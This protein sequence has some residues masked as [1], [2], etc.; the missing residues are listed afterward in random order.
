[1]S[2]IYLK[3]GGGGGDGTE[4]RIHKRA[5]TVRTESFPIDGF[6][7]RF[8]WSKEGKKGKK[9]GR[10]ECTSESACKRSIDTMI[11]TSRPTTPDVKSR[12]QTDDNREPDIQ[13]H[14]KTGNAGKL[15]TTEATKTEPNQKRRKR[16]GVGAIVKAFDQFEDFLPVFVGRSGHLFGYFYNNFALLLLFERRRCR[17]RLL[18]LLLTSI[19]WPAAFVPF[20]GVNRFAFL[21]FLP[22]LLAVAGRLGRPWSLVE[23]LGAVEAA[24]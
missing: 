12:R 2:I 18:L 21:G 22:A 17:L 20:R 13:Q 15:R 3:G 1:M 23:R 9:E 4:I 24:S 10:R 11:H 14:K 8:C 19:V 16:T 6:A 5:K 7:K